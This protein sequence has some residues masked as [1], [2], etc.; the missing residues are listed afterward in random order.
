MKKVGKKLIMLTNEVIRMNMESNM[1]FYSRQ[2][3][4]VY[5]YI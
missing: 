5:T 3:A 1:H 4:D 2:K